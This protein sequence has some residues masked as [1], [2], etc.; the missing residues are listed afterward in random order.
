LLHFGYIEITTLS[1]IEEEEEDKKREVVNQHILRARCVGATVFPNLPAVKIPSH[2]SC[3]VFAR[4]KKSIRLREQEM[5][6][7]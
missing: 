6:T 7:A 4:E 1:R 5:Q 2:L 3:A